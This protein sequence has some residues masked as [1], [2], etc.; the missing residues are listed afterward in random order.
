MHERLVRHIGALTDGAGPDYDGA[1]LEAWAPHRGMIRA[2]ARS[3]SRV[4][5]LC[6]LAA[7]PAN[8]VDSTLMF[9]RGTPV[10]SAVQQFAW[11]VIEERCH[12]QSF[13]RRQRSFWAYDSQ[14]RPTSEGMRYSIKI[15]SDVPWKKTEPSAYIEMTIVG[16]GHL[17]LTALRSSLIDCSF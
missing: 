4:S 7:S 12:Y 9:A 6:A 5:A 8:G 2:V 17:R 10:P 11:R 13:E 1:R 16:D 15:V 14:A 3:L